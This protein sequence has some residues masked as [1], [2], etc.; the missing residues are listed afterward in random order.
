[1]QGYARW[2]QTPVLSRDQFVHQ[3]FFPEV[4]ELGSLC[5]GYHLGFDLVRVAVRCTTGRK[6]NREAFRVE[7]CEHP[8]HPAIYLQVVSNKQSFMRFASIPPPQGRKTGRGRVT[9]HGRFLDLRQTVYALTGEAGDLESDCLKFGIES[10]KL[11]VPRLGG[12]TEDLMAY[13]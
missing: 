11:S 7:L 10:R 1:Q 4:Y 5:V 3:V 9:F 13:N 8:H 2:E 6:R 12:V